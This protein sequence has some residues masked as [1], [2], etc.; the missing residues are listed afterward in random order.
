MTKLTVF[1]DSFPRSKVPNAVN[2][3]AM[4]VDKNSQTLKQFVDIAV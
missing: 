1:K 2:V 3:N 4:I